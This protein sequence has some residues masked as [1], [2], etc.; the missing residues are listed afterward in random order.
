VIDLAHDVAN[1]ICSK[2][3]Q[4]DI[5][6]LVSHAALVGIDLPCATWSL[7]RRAPVWSSMPSPLR[8]SVGSEIWGLPHLSDGDRRKVRIGNVQV[9]HAVKVIRS[10]V[11]GGTPGYLENPLTSRVWL[12]IARLLKKE[13]KAGLVVLRRTCLCQYGVPWKKPTRLLTWGSSSVD[14]K[15]CCGKGVC[16][17]T[18]RPHLTLT[19]ISG[20]GKFLTSQAQVYPKQFVSHLLPQ[21]LGW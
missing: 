12:V 10:C 17:R 15:W 1:N 19:G 13:L 21:L 2:P 20:N 5:D 7:A 14:L 8:S 18:K 3:V 6:V 16:S 11:A 4:S 9:K